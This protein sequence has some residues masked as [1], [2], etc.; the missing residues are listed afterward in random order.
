M[1]CAV[2]DAAPMADIS[3]VLPCASRCV[4]SMIHSLVGD[5]EGTNN[6]TCNRLSVLQP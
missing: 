4:A 1:A 2:Y 6:N 3:T 5:D